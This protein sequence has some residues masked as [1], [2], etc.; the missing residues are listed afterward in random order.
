MD[1]CGSVVLDIKSLSQY[2]EKCSG[3]GSPK[4]TVGNHLHFVPFHISP[5]FIAILS[6]SIS[7]CSYMDD[8]WHVMDLFIL[9]N[10]SFL[11]K[12]LSRKGSNRMERQNADDLEAD[13]ASKKIV[14]KGQ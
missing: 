6:I 13:D 11:Q 7:P 9:I 1:K 14:V 4:L 12:V 10:I 2:A 8:G 5:L 3:A